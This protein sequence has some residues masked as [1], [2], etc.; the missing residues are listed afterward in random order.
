MHVLVELHHGTD[1]N[2]LAEKERLVV[3]KRLM[4]CSTSDR[5]FG[6]LQ[7][8][9]TGA[10]S[11]MLRSWNR[12]TNDESVDVV[13]GEAVDDDLHPFHFRQQCSVPFRNESLVMPFVR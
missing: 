11:V 7:T 2:P 13:E 3:D 5:W 6:I 12:A 8:W 10:R 1:S 9:W 4:E